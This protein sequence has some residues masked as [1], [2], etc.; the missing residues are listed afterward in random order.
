MSVYVKQIS[1]LPIVEEIN[2]SENIIV[3]D[4]GETKQLPINKVSPQNIKKE[5]LS[6]ELLNYLATKEDAWPSDLPKPS[7]GGYGYTEQGEQTV[8]TWD[9]DTSGKE[10]LMG[11]MYL[12]ESVK[13]PSADEIV[14]AII[15]FANGDTISVASADIQVIDDTTFGID[16]GTRVVCIVATQDSDMGGMAVSKGVYFFK[17]GVDYITSLTYGTPDTVHKIDEKYLPAS[18]GAGLP[19]VSGSGKALVSINGEWKETEGYGYTSIQN[20]TVVDNET[21]TTQ[22]SGMPGIAMGFVDAV[23]PG[24][25]ETKYTVT[26]DGREY[27]CISKIAESDGGFFSPV[28]LGAELDFET[29]DVDFSDY[30]FV[31]I[32]NYP[33]TESHTTCMVA[34]ENPGE[35]VITIKVDVPTYTP[36]D[37]KL[38]PV[39]TDSTPGISTTNCKYIDLTVGFTNE[40]LTQLRRELDAHP[41]WTYLVDRGRGHYERFWRISPNWGSLYLYGSPYDYTL[42]ELGDDGTLDLDNPRSKYDSISIGQNLH[43]SSNDS[44]YAADCRLSN[45]GV[46]HNV[47]WGIAQQLPSYRALRLETESMIHDINLNVSGCVQAKRT[48]FHNWTRGGSQHFHDM[49]IDEDDQLCLDYYENRTA[50][51]KACYTIPVIKEKCFIMPSS[52]PGSTKKFKI[53]V[54]DSGTISATEVTE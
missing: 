34:T 27:E 31:I 40:D 8:I 51:P 47:S 42:Y 13:A 35:Y 28:M 14:G 44:Q 1:E 46:I 5:Q 15:D 21:V 32:P 24:Y 9:G 50:A 26:F 18:G 11:S 53:T 17:E 20:T 22:D 10:T 7:V 36:I 33:I 49:Y 23:V 45:D 41:E 3:N 38:L 6:D 30:P 16:N 39:A 54:D 19:N 25:G 29:G 2:G 4:N 43:L 12:I 52:T 48:I 37:P